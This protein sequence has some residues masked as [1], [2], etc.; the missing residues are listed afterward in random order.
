MPATLWL[1][2]LS[3]AAAVIAM[4]KAVRDLRDKGWGKA[5]IDVLGAAIAVALI[6]VAGDVRSQQQA[7]QQILERKIT[8]A[9]REASA[10]ASNT[11]TNPLSNDVIA[12]LSRA[13]NS[14]AVV[15]VGV[16]CE[17]NAVNLCK[18]LCSA[19][20]NS[21]VTLRFCSIGP[22]LGAAT[23]AVEVISSG[24]AFD[25]SAQALSVALSKEGID[26]GSVPHD[27]N[28]KPGPANTPMPSVTVAVNHY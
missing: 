11:R 14:A 1:Q 9:S 12:R 8:L 25:R 17:P 21:H 10:A 3:V 20:D 19:V 6:F 7:T 27:P 15:D 18:D 23:H 5:L 2:I 28:Y 4:V 24:A 22:L 26:S 16:E 13:L